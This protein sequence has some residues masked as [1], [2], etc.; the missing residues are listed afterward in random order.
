MCAA[1]IAFVDIK[2]ASKA[3][4]AE[5]KFEDRLL[6]TEYYEPSSMLG[7]SMDSGEGAV[8]AAL[9]G[10]EKD[11][12]TVSRHHEQQARFATNSASTNTTTNHGHGLVWQLRGL[13]QH[14]IKQNQNI[15][16]LMDLQERRLS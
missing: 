8:A 5:H 9:V 10:G 4:L 1:T 15:V 16:E 11:E 3:H 13:P 6:T 12:R 2:S 7:S 14:K